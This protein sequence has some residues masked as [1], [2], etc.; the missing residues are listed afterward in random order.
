[1]EDKKIAALPSLTTPD[2]DIK[3]I[4]PTN[5]TQDTDNNTLTTDMPNDVKISS[6]HPR[7]SMLEILQNFPHIQHRY[8]HKI[9][10]S[11]PWKQYNT[12]PN[13]DTYYKAISYFFNM[14]KTYDSQF[15]IHPYHTN[16]KQLLVA[17]Q[18]IVETRDIVIEVYRPRA[19]K[20]DKSIITAPEAITIGAPSD[21]S[22]QIYKSLME[23][24]PGVISGQFDMVIGD[25]NIIKSG[26]FIPFAHGLLSQKDK[27]DAICK[28]DKFINEHT[29]I[30]LRHCLS[31]YE[32]FEL[33]HDETTRLGYTIKK[34]KQKRMTT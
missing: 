3:Q 2:I 13:E 15:Q 27:N 33:L 20:K 8:C 6:T 31:I 16:L 23:K 28:H 18:A 25:N 11:I 4:E 10:V 19:I 34:D 24:W 5:I 14:V 21:I 1:M 22:V 32:R 9:K 29:G 17:I 7:F 12:I 26:Y 30:K